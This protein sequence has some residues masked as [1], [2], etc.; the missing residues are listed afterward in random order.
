MAFHTCIIEKTLFQS[1]LKKLFQSEP[2]NLIVKQVSFFIN[3][4]NIQGD[5]FRRAIGNE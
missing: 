2:S 3:Y 1:V 4:F 5:Y